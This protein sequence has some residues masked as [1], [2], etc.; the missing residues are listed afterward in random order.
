VPPSV[1]RL[2]PLL[3]RVVI[4]FRFPKRNAA[5]NAKAVG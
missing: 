5:A 2:E 1:T 4:S 3:D